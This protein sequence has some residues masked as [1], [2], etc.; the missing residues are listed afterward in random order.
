MTARC[1]LQDQY[2]NSIVLARRTV[3]TWRITSEEAQSETKDISFRYGV[4]KK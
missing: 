2:Q 3:S 4:M 1:V